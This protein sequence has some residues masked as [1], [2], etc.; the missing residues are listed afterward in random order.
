MFRKWIILFLIFTG[1]IL[2]EAPS[3]YAFIWGDM[4]KG[5]Y[6]TGDGSTIDANKVVNSFGTKTAGTDYDKPGTVPTAARHWTTFSTESN[7]GDAT[8]DI[9]GSDRW[10]FSHASATDITMLDGMTAG[11]RKFIYFSTSNVTFRFDLGGNLI[12]NHGTKVTFNTGEWC[13]VSYDGTN[14][15]CDVYHDALPVTTFS[16]V[17]TIHDDGDSTK[18]FAVQCSGI[19]PDTTVHMYPPDSDFTIP[20][21]PVGKNVDLDIWQS[22]DVDASAFSVDG[23]IC[24]TPAE[25]TINSGPKTYICD[26]ASDGAGTFE[27]KIPNMPANWDGG[28]IGIELQL[29]SDEVTP[30]GTIEFD[31]SIESRGNDELIDGTWITL[32]G[33]IYFEDAETANTT[34]DTQYKTFHC[35]TKSAMVAAGAGGDTLFVKATR[36]YDDATHDTSTQGVWIMGT[37]VYYQINSMNEFE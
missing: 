13:W 30:A 12:G 31:M 5:E 29:V 6:C 8:P 11:D 28:N 37:T 25:Q 36:H 4:A 35:A 14:A 7:T 22:V 27:F 21:T 26:C 18:K 2:S 17:V 3:T 15:R 32:N 20:A 9:S 33:E 10:V 24:T 23:T 34:V 16:D 19:T 1:F